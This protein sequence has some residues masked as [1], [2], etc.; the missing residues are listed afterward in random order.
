MW[1]RSVLRFPERADYPFDPAGPIAASSPSAWRPPGAKS[2][3]EVGGGE[4]PGAAVPVAA[5]RG[6]AAR[7]IAL[8]AGEELE[9]MGVEGVEELGDLPRALRPPLRQ[10]RR[11]AGIT[12]TFGAAALGGCVPRQPVLSGAARLLRRRAD[13]I[14]RIVPAT[15]QT[16]STL[17][18]GL[19]VP[20]PHSPGRQRRARRALEAGAHQPGSARCAEKLEGGF[21][22]TAPMWCCRFCT[23]SR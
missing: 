13:E 5:G 15:G 18:G 2:G 23:R 1:G 16:I 10:H 12:G 22:S 21:A 7:P 9:D 3:R 19:P 20:S 11:A 17:R 4:C 6:D 14:R 8:T